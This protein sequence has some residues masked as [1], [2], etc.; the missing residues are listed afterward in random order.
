MKKWYLTYPKF[1]E[2]RCF[3]WTIVS[4]W[5]NNP[6][7]SRSTPNEGL[8]ERNYSNIDSSMIT[9]TSPRP[10]NLRPGKKCQSRV[11]NLNY[12]VGKASFQETS[13]QLL[14]ASS[15][16]NIKL[17]HVWSLKNLKHKQT[18]PFYYQFHFLKTHRVFSF[19]FIP[20]RL[21]AW[22]PYYKM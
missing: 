12:I 7:C 21:K 8:V 5:Q 9:H 1:N 2:T 11:L 3:K 15:N 19:L 17:S 16:D 18:S 13:H 6:V 14:V 10:S 4:I 20:L 22:T